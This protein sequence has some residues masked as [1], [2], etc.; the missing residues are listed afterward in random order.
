MVCEVSS[1]LRGSHH[2]SNS[3]HPVF[4]FSVPVFSCKAFLQLCP[5]IR[6]LCLFSTLNYNIPWLLS[7]GEYGLFMLTARCSAPLWHLYYKLWP[8]VFISIYWPWA[9]REQILFVPS[10]VG[11]PSKEMDAWSLPPP[12]ARLN[13]LA[14]TKWPLLGLDFWSELE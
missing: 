14:T 1:L 13:Q 11:A 12:R 8:S 3:S 2:F 5:Q 7:G 9:P 4:A 6:I 10:L